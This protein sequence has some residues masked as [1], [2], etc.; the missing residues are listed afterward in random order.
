MKTQ[1]GFT[2]LELVIAL[3][4]FAL[5]SSVM[6]G[7]LGFA[8]RSSE[9][10]ETKAESASSMRLTHAFL[11]AQ[12][13]GQHPMRMRKMVEFPLLFGGSR[14]E[15]RYAAPL[16]AR[17][18]GGGVWYYRLTVV[19]EG[20]KSRLVLERMVPDVDAGNVPEFYRSDRSVLA[21]DIGELRLSYYGRDQG[22]SNTT[23][24]TWRER[25]EDPNRLPL[26]VRIDVVPRHAPPWPT[27]LVAP[28]QAPESGCRR[29]DV[30]TERCVGMS[31]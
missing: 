3:T 5:L 12:L 24:P 28:R 30:A 1:R 4:L 10:G 9:A 6:Y 13:E 16:P 23:Q 8:G 15:L 27:L 19:K 22:A 21:E 14:D 29:W 20:E 11:R 17:I 26:M 18:T 31:S 7:A 2:L 25:W